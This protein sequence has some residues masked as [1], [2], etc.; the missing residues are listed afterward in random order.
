MNSA[1]SPNPTPAERVL[2]RIERDPVSNCWVFDHAL[3]SKGY[4]TVSVG[5]SSKLAHRVVYEALRGPIATG[6]TLDHR[7]RKRTCVNPAHLT[8]MTVQA[9]IQRGKE[10]RDLQDP[11]ACPKGHILY[12]D[13]LVWHLW[14]QYG[15]KQCLRCRVLRLAKQRGYVKARKAAV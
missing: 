7:C 1:L 5:K 10:Y 13:N 11:K 14:E 2:R 12:E 15:I 4:A 8:P 9:N 3:N 6:L